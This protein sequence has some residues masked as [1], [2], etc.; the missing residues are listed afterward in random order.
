MLY[1]GDLSRQKGV[2]VLLDAYR[3]VGTDVPL[4]LIGR[5]F[6]DF[7]GE[8]PPGATVFC[9]WPHPA[10]LQAWKR[11][12]FGLA[13]SIWHEPCA[14][15]V[16]EGMAMGKPMVVSDLGGMPDLVEDGETGLVVAPGPVPLAGALR[17]LLGDADLR[18][19]MGLAG[20]E[21]VRHFQA[22]AVVG[23]IEAVY[24]ELSAR[25][26]ALAAE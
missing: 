5:R 18:R 1:V 11:C 2:H 10:I 4:V 7:P 21:K 20:R 25:R 12:L 22:R 8:L 19:R 17:R 9:A 3:S 24:Q 15:V 6:P 13:P 23:R 16:M 14:T 26:A